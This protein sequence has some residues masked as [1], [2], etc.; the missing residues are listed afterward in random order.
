LREALDKTSG[1]LKAGII[2]S[3]GWRAEAASVPVLAPLLDNTDVTI[4]TAA[5]TALGRIGGSDPAQALSEHRREVAGAVQPALNEALLKCAERLPAQPAIQIYRTLFEPGAPVQV[6]IAAWRGLAV[7]DQA[8]R[9]ALV[10]KALSGTDRPIQVAALKLLRE[11]RDPE[12]VHACVDQWATLP[13]DAQLAVLDA[14]VKLGSEALPTARRASQS[15]DATLRAGAWKALA[16]LNDLN[17]VAGLASAAAHG[18]P[19]EQEIARDSL[20]RLRGADARQ[21]LLTQLDR[22]E[23]AEKAEL[24]RAIGQRGD[25][26]SVDVLLKNAGAEDQAVRIASL[27]SLRILAPPQAISP[28]LDVAAKSKSDEQRE[29]V[30]KAIFAV[31]E[32]SPNK[33]QTARSIVEAMGRFPTSE[34]RQILPLLSELATPEALRAAETASRDQ[35]PELAKEAVRVLAQWPNASPAPHLLE[36][37]RASNQSTLQTLALRG[38][39]EVAGQEPD[40]TKRLALLREALN[41]SRGSEE[42]KQ[43]LGQVGQIPTKDALDLALEYFINPDLVNEAALAAIS[44][45]EKLAVSDPKLADSVAAKV[46]DRVNE[47]DVARRAWALRLKPSSGASFIRDWVV[48]GPYR[49]AGIVGAQ[50]VFNIAFGPEKPSQKVE[51]KTVAPADQVS[52]SALFPGAENCVAYLRTRILAPEACRAVLLMGSD[53]GIKAWLNGRV[54]HSNNVD[55]G[56]VV[57]QDATPIQLNKGANELVLKITQ[58]GGG[59]SACA[60]ITGS[61]GRPIPGLLVERPTDSCPVLEASRAP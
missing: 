41:V 55:R 23:G 20:A 34:R 35:D 22:S 53:D 37:A 48:C 57:D 51:W 12:L 13:A 30:L 18:Q 6:R 32:A 44:I 47:G 10:T 60:R 42:K 40:T 27:E 2:D 54:V 3:L 36:L 26:D 46:L 33:D 9:N 21:A 11:L 4:A 50:A 8:G 25:R 5:A 56:Q 39:I 43:A 52:L 45:A 31:C 19:A 58:G 7:S 29:P 38:L 59:W 17:A 15:A 1:V 16:D 49:Q 24:L 14:Q 28:L 61:D